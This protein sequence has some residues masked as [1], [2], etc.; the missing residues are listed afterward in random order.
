FFSIVPVKTTDHRRSDP[1]NRPVASPPAAY[2]ATK[3]MSSI[4]W[5]A[6]APIEYAWVG[7]DRSGRHPAVVGPLPD[8]WT[9]FQVG[10]DDGTT[11]L[12][13]ESAQAP[14]LVSPYRL[15]SLQPNALPAR[16][17]FPVPISFPAVRSA[18]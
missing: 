6:I 9:R 10:A 7:T 13:L 1:P 14:N 17:P 18:Q 5:Q 8:K 15:S 16:Q 12:Y 3:G 11:I 4:T 2:V